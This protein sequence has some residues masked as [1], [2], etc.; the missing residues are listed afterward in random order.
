MDY[1]LATVEKGRGE[2]GTLG[3]RRGYIGVRVPWCPCVHGVHE[4]K[5]SEVQ[6]KGGAVRAW[7]LTR[8]TRMSTWVEWERGVCGALVRKGREEGAGQA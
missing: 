5:G 6:E 8:G 1:L 7:P 4:K 2:E 3:E